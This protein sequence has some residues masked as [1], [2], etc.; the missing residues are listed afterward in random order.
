M[1]RTF[2][3]SRGRMVA[4]GDASSRAASP[5]VPWR[6]RTNRP[7][8]RCESSSSS[9]C[10]PTHSSSDCCDV[11]SAHLAKGLDDA[12]MGSAFLGIKLH[13][14]FPSRSS[15]RAVC[16]RARPLIA[17]HDA[18]QVEVGLRGRHAPVS[19]LRH[20]SRRRA[21]RLCRGRRASGPHRRVATPRRTRRTAG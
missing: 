15:H 1:G 14:G 12:V 4:A 6:S 13:S 17:E 5:D 8:A 3:P 2:Y 7:N 21:R 16:A 19:G 9:P 18:G 11:V 20:G 10:S